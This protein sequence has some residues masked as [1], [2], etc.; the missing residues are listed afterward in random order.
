[1]P[2]DTQTVKIVQVNLGRGMAAYKE[3]LQMAVNQ[4]ITLLLLQE[5]YIGSKGHVTCNRRVIQKVNNII[6]K[7]V[8]SAVI[9][10]DPTY[11]IIENPE[12]ISENIV[13]FIIKV[14]NH[15]IGILNVYLEKNGDLDED[16][17]NIVKIA[18]NM[19]TEDIILAGDFNA[20]SPWWG[21]REED[22]RGL[23]LSEM[24]AEM[25]MNILNQGNDPTFYQYRAGKLYSSLVDV[26]ACTSSLLHKV[27]KWK[28]D[29]DF[30]TLS[31]HR[32]IQF[33]I[34]II[35][36]KQKTSPRKSTRLFNTAKANWSIFRD[37]LNEG[38][39]ND[40]ITEI[41]VNLIKTTNDLEDILDK[42]IKQVSIASK[43]AIPP[44][45]K[46]INTTCT[47]WWTKE[48]EAERREL[49]RLRRRIR[50]ANTRRKPFL[51]QEFTAAKEKYVSNIMFTI[52]ESWKQ[53]CT[54]QE[55]E[56]IWQSIYRI[57]RK[58]TTISEDKLLRL[59]E[60]TLNPNDSAMLLAKV[61][62]PEDEVNKDTEEQGKVRDESNAIIKD[63]RYDSISFREF[64][65][66]EIEMVLQRMN[67]KKAPGEDGITSDICYEA[68]KTSPSTLK[69][70]FNKCLELGH[71]PEIWKKAVIKVIPKPGKDD[72]SVP[73]SY[74]P[75]GLL[76][77]FGKILE[78]LFVG[79]LLWQLGSEDKLNSF[80]YGFMPQRSTED[81][82]Y[83]TMT[84]IRQGIKEKMIVVV[85]SLDIEGAFDNAWWPQI[86]REM[87]RK[88][89]SS[90]ILR[91]VT[92]Y[93]SF[94]SI[95]LKYA[96]AE[97]TKSTTKGCIQGSTCGPILWNILLDP[98]LESISKLNVRIQAY[99][100]DILV[101]AKGHSA[102]AVE[103]KLNPALE[104]VMAWGKKHK[105]NFAPHKT[106]A[107]V[108]TK[109]LSYEIPTIKMNNIII[110][111]SSSL[112]V[113][114]VTFD[115]NLNFVEHLDGVLRKALNIYKTISRTARANWGFNSE[116]VKTIYLAV[117]EPTILHAASV[118]ATVAKKEYMRKRLERITRMFAIKICKGH[119]TISFTSS[120]LLSGIIPLDLRAL[121]HLSL[122][123]IKRGKP[124]AQLPGRTVEK[125]ISPF[126]LPHP[127]ERERVSFKIVVT[128][129][130][131]NAI[132]GLKPR[133]YT[134]GSKL[135][136]KVG[137]AV[138]VWREGKEIL[139]STFRLESYCSVYQAELTAILKALDMM[140]KISK[141]KKA[142][143]L[144]D[145]RSAL[146]CLT[147]STSLQPLAVEIRERL[148][149]LKNK[150]G[151]VEFYWVKAHIGIPGNE[152]ADEL[153]KKAALSNKQAAVYDKC[154]LSFAKRLTRDSTCMGWQQ[155]YNEAT[156]GAVTKIFFPDIRQAHSTL[157]NIKLD[158]VKTQLLTG[159][160][161]FKAYLFKYK[162]TQSP[163]CAC[164]SE[165]DE[166]ILHLL[167]D[168]PRFAMKRLECEQKMGIAI[169]DTTLK[170]AINNDDCRTHFLKYA[171]IVVPTAGKANGSKI[172]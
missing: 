30:V 149:E 79:R 77:V 160:G 48:L 82:L 139:K 114:G 17:R 53:L 12:Y 146:E 67:P 16:I 136:D 10:V 128:Q 143:I 109:K 23:H 108:I 78:K 116:I 91:L 27:E 55:K 11:L 124:L 117:V 52:T 87:K 37:V 172:V 137:G 90:E 32:A 22:R 95:L 65:E 54:K 99:A 127:A 46:K 162:L 112:K 3:S 38:L 102:N 21:S 141:L 147:D 58:C 20:K 40:K 142:I 4:K 151:D 83:D 39:E 134:D 150:D 2:E 60:K 171:E 14:G 152:R 50:F 161:G 76:P 43:R 89:V 26:T 68:Y 97:V 138:S 107:I 103:E 92:S 33:Q 5:P 93:L 42:Y 9:V 126:C 63:L 57:I 130:E 88:K 154:P 158:N 125:P 164:S 19:D 101:I 18:Q 35:I 7:P 84:V 148:R 144:S 51:I 153:A 104:Q 72:Y 31:D 71:F 15:S 168:C 98:L 24:I 129:E 69:A 44:I 118:W 111:P 120:V 119:R 140:C 8:K 62:Y 106:Q 85:V 156:T 115:T 25:D 133:I 113:L 28:V 110:K 132:D 135:E 159:H 96:G 56:T 29:P 59:G 34:N 80:Q 105:L 166:T 169:K 121:E 131:E 94:R 86:I 70:I 1:M 157:K 163:S 122:Y 61:F 36:D 100:D 145:S 13:G 41:K 81:A 66:E 45:S 155:R 73:K 75:I 74:R 47:P 123:E 165:V 49:I 170:Y 64:T 6:D 167:I